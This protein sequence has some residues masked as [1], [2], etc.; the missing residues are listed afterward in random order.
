MIFKIQDFT[1]T[2]ITEMRLYIGKHVPNHI[3]NTLYM[4]TDEVKDKL[5][6]F[7]GVYRILNSCK[8]YASTPHLMDK[9]DDFL[10]HSKKAYE[11]INPI[12]TKYTLLKSNY[13]KY[14]T[15]KVMSKLIEKYY[16][17]ID[18]LID[19]HIVLGEHIQL[20]KT[21]AIIGVDVEADDSVKEMIREARKIAEREGA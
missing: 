1:E 6:I 10:E 8:N 11:E 5:I 7:T 20:T 17:Q 9:I 2:E 3:L 16:S 21:D 18:L 19:L 15:I 13:A 12:L 4:L 14:E